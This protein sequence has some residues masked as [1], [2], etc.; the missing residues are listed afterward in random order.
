[1][2]TVSGVEIVI[3]GH[4]HNYQRWEPLDAA[5]GPD[6]SGTTQLVVG[7]GGHGIQ[8]FVGEDERVEV[9]VDEKGAYG[10]LRLELF[11]DSARFTFITI[12]SKTRDAG[13]IPCDRAIS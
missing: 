9:S 12:D 13:D 3:A 2:L 4:D 10:A 11:P 8:T 6:L 1:L 5:G 7:T